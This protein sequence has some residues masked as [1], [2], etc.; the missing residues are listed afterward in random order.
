MGNTSRQ[1]PSADEES[2]FSVEHLATGLKERSARG[3]AFTF[4]S[5][6]FRLVLQ[7]GSSAVLG[8]LLTPQD[9]GLIGMISAVTGI[10]SVFGNLGL[11]SAIVQ[12]PEINHRQMSSLFWLNAALGL[13]LA[14]VTAALA[15]GLAWFYHDPRLTEVTIVLGLGFFVSGLGVQHNALLRRKMRFGALSIIEITA[16]VTGT[17]TAIWLASKD[18]GYWAL[19][20]MPIASAFTVTALSWLVC[21]WRPGIFF[22]KSGIRSMVIFGGNL[23]LFGTLNYFVRNFDNVL[24]GWRWGAPELGQYARAYNL[25]LFPISQINAPISNVIVPALSRLQDDPARFRS[26]YLKGLNLVAYITMPLIVVMAVFSS[27]IIRVILG[28]Q[29][30]QAGQLFRIL[31]VAAFL[32][33]IA[34]TTGWLFTALNRTAV[35]ARWGLIS[36]PLFV[37]SFAAGLPWRAPGVAIGYA[38]ASWLLTYPCFAMAVKGTPVSMR[39]VGQAIY[40]PFTAATILGLAMLAGHSFFAAYGTAWMLAFSGLACAAAISLMLL[41]SRSLRMDLGGIVNSMRAL[42]GA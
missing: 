24:I 16:G 15:P 19:A 2:Q 25:L 12:Q 41:F 4:G 10:L 33:P 37:A 27:E 34:N 42:R 35:M 40:R 3:A 13:A 32:Q 21:R 17:V 20:L 8:R 39:D 18:F 6:A 38:A 1:T 7:L 5:Q 14:A 31:A 11:S 30:S 36:G 23:T 9:Y 22:K 26:Y 28:P 29:W